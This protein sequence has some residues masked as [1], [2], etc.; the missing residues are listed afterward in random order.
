MLHLD[1]LTTVYKSKYFNDLPILSKQLLSNH[2]EFFYQNLKPIDDNL[3]DTINGYNSIKLE[4]D[5]MIGHMKV[6]TQI[7][8]MYQL[9]LKLY[10]FNA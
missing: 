9:R 8:Y 2:F 6:L 7:R 3:E 1:E 5:D 4:G 10:T